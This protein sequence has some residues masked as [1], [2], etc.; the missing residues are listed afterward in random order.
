MPA[1]RGLRDMLLI[2]SCGILPAGFAARAHGEAAPDDPTRSAIRVYQQHLS[3]MRHLHCRFV[4]SCSQYAAEAIARYGLVEG[5][6]R[7]AD[8]LMR[9]NRSSDT[10][11]PR[12]GEGLLV[13]PVDAAPRSPTAARVPSWL[14]LAAGPAGP[15]RAAALAP[16]RAERLEE[17]VA[18]A[19]VLVER[20]DCERASAEFQRAGTLADTVA[21]DAW[22]YARIGHCYFDASQWYFA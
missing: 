1:R 9:C 3:A 22:A 11:Y 10:R 12:S 20:G 21:A 16:G 18:F 15:P 8:R 2:L 14:L 4:P 6:A 17:A 5:S 19:R 7:A 13:D